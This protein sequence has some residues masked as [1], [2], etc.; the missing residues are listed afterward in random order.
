MID[1]A[2]EWGANGLRH[3]ANGRVVVIVDVL[4]FSTAVS[5]AVARGARVVPCDPSDERA[6]LAAKRGDA[7][8]TLSPASLLDVPA[9]T[10]LVLPSPNGSLLAAI[11]HEHGASAVVAGCLR[12]ATAVAEWIRNRGEPAAVIAAGEQSSH[13][14]IR[15]AVEDWLG[16]RAI[17]SHVRGTTDTLIA[18]QTLKTAI[19]SSLSGRE[20]IERGYRA[21]VDIAA[22]LDA[23]AVVPILEGGAFVRGI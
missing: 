6:Q 1:I 3:L 13:N 12:N 5:V 2:V 14:T 22:E 8:F 20:L 7:G 15:F 21:D 17:I 16:A 9:G 11:A 23:D 19:E 18:T 4:S 10:S